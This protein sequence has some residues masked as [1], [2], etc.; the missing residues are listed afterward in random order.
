[1]LET[2]AK[3]AELSMFGSLRR[4]GLQTIPNPFATGLLRLRQDEH[5]TTISL[6]IPNPKTVNPIDP[7][8][9]LNPKPSTL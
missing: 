9:A 5:L 4:C 2:Q 1:M 7:F 3:R 6:V 8:K